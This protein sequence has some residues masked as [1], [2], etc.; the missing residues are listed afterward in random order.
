MGILGNEK[1]STRKSK[2]LPFVHVY[3][4]DVLPTKFDLTRYARH[5]ITTHWTLFLEKLKR[6]KSTC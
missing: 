5:V 4:S 2:K 3:L 6:Y 1:K